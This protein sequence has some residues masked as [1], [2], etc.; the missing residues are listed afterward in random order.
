MAS[1]S[2]IAVHRAGVWV[3]KGVIVTK[4]LENNR[5]YKQLGCIPFHSTLLACFFESKHELAVCRA[6]WAFID[7]AEWEFAPWS[8]P[9]GRKILFLM[10]WRGPGLPA[11]NYRSC[12]LEDAMQD[13]TVKYSASFPLLASQPM[14]K[15]GLQIVYVI[16]EKNEIWNTLKYGKKFEYI[17]TEVAEHMI[18]FQN[19]CRTHDVQVKTNQ[20]AGLLLKGW[21]Q[22]TWWLGKND[23]NRRWFYTMEALI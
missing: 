23:V 8:F 21:L 5:H 16:C 19:Y 7:Q 22:S 1:V 6:R 11:N 14:Y 4:V 10:V 2:E 18:V 3:S 20:A 9:E 12:L 13:Q 17:S 15:C